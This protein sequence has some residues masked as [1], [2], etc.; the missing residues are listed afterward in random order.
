MQESPGTLTP[1][2]EA[3]IDQAADGHLI[4]NDDTT[5]QVLQL[6]RRPSGIFAPQGPSI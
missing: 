3:L 5:Q 6:T 2:H 4:H 1:V